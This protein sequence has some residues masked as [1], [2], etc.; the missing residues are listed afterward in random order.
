LS[1]LPGISNQYYRKVQLLRS[2]F[3]KTICFQS[4]I[5]DRTVILVSLFRPLLSSLE[6]GLASITSLCMYYSL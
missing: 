2:L 3:I 5:A 1:P 4:Q 6:F